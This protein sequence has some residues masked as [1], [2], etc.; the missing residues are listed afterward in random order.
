M[1][2]YCL[3]CEE[4]IPEVVFNYSTANFG[5][6]LCRFHQNWLKSLPDTVTPEALMLYFFLKNY[7]IDAEL[8]KFD[9]FK[10]IDIAIPSAKVNI[11]IDGKHHTFNPDQALSDLKR[12]YHSFRKGFLTLRIPNTLV[13]NHLEEAAEYI[14]DFIL[15]NQKKQNKNN[16]RYIR[17]W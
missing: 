3:E 16:W 2:H 17:R 1:R 7:G 11:E 8:E 13:H 5:I 14:A 6:P 4:Q 15:E 12:T 10:H 9:G